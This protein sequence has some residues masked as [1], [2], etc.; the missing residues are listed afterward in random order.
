M[1][2]KGS[3]LILDYLS[4]QISGA[5]CGFNLSDA[6]HREAEVR[7]ADRLSD[8]LLQKEPADFDW[9]LADPTLYVG[10]IWALSLDEEMVI[11]INT[12]NCRPSRYLQIYITK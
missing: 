1:H 4:K 11:D 2:I 3:T 5:V 9:L 8:L 12:D 6:L 10:N 7:I